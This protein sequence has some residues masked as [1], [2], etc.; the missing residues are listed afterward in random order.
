MNWELALKVATIVVSGLTL[1]DKG[2]ELIKKRSISRR[3]VRTPRLA[4]SWY[5]SFKKQ[6][7]QLQNSTKNDLVLLSNFMETSTLLKKAI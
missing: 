1:L 6:I 5:L 7:S 4:R 3:F 2:Y